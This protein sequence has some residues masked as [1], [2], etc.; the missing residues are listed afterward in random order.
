MAPAASWRCKP[1]GVTL[2]LA[3]WDP[4]AQTDLAA[5]ELESMEWAAF[6]D[7]IADE[8]TGS[9]PMIVDFDP[10]NHTWTADHAVALE[11]EAAE[12][13]RQLGERKVKRR[14]RRAA[15]ERLADIDE[16]PAHSAQPATMND[17]FIDHHGHPI[18]TTLRAMAEQCRDTTIVIKA[19]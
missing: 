10:W 11:R 2:Y 17:Y 16:L 4:A 9:F 18:A 1:V 7:Y 15:A 12:V 8:L 14:Y 13:E 19:L 5:I 3:L 6:R